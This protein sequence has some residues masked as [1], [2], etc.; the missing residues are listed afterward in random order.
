M[1]IIKATKKHSKEIS[2]LMLLDLENPNS[3]FPQEMINN[4][5]EHV[6]EENIIKEFEDPRL[7]AFLA[8]N[9]KRVLGFIVGYEP[10]LGGAMI[11]YI[12]AKEDGLKERLL[13]RFIKECKSKNITEVI[14][15]TFEFMKNNAFFKSQGFTLMKKESLTKNLEILW[16]KLDLN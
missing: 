14:T 2:K 16:H 12:N 3:K 6:K 11:H 7:I 15:D 5:R 9:E 4:F 10:D 1:K 8:I 13:K